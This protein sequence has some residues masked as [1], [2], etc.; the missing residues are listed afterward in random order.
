V[1]AALVSIGCQ[2]ALGALRQ[3][4]DMMRATADSDDLMHELH[5]RQARH[6]QR[7]RLMRTAT[8]TRLGPTASKAAHSLA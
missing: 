5:Q 6:G 4:D 3:M 1:N 2:V 8:G 7:A